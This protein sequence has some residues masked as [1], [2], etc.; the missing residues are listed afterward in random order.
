[1]KQRTTDLE[2]EIGERVRAEDQLREA[3]GRAEAANKTKS[4]FLA[5]MSHEIRTPLNAIMGFTEILA[6]RIQDGTQKRHLEIYSSQWQDIDY[7]HR[8]RPRPFQSGPPGSL[9]YIL[10]PT[11]VCALLHE[12]ELVYA[13]KAS[14]EGIAT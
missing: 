12:I 4:R 3:V 9:S 6:T 5:N 7:T 8:R 1:M 13:P 14:G 2:T 10:G 11:D